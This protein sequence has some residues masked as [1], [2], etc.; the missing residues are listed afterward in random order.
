MESL[1]K[2]IEDAPSGLEID[3]AGNLL[4]E[5][6]LQTQKTAN[7][8]RDEEV[9]FLIEERNEAVDKVSPTSAFVG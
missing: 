8:I 6:V 4:L 2:T 1:L 5:R 3:M 7:Q 9:A